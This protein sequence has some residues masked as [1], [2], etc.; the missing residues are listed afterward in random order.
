MS[1]SESTVERV[2]E[3]IAL[4]IHA[5]WWPEG[6]LPLDEGVEAESWHREIARSVVALINQRKAGKGVWLDGV[7]E[8][9]RD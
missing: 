8:G 4:G 5:S 9:W 1:D 7:G 6:Q 3:I 2:A